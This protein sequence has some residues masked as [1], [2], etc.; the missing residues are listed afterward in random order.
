IGGPF[1]G[2]NY[3]NDHIGHD[4]DGDGFSDLNIPY[5]P[6]DHLP[7]VPVNHAPVANFTYAPT[8]PSSL[9]VV[10]FNDTSTD[11]DGN[12][13]I[14]NWSWIFGDGNSSY[15]QN[16]THTYT[17]NG[18]F[19]VIL[20][21][22][23]SS[24]VE[25]S[26][27]QNI[28]ILNIGPIANFSYSPSN[29]HT[30]IDVIFNS[31]SIDYDGSIVNWSWDFD[32]GNISYGE[33]TTHQFLEG[34][35]N[36]VLFIRDNTG[37]TNFTNK[38]ITVTNIQ[39]NVDFTYFPV[40]PTTADIISFIDQSSDRNERNIVNW[41]WDFDDGN[42]SYT[43]NPTHQ[44]ANSGDYNVTLT[45]TDN[46]MATNSTTKIVPVSNLP[47]IANFSYNPNNPTSLDL[48][49]FNDSSYDSDGT[50]VSWYWNFGDG[51]TSTSQN[52][53]HSYADN[54]TYLVS[55]TVTDDDGDNDTITKQV[56]LANIIPIVNF[57]YLPTTP[58]T[59][60]LIT[61]NDSSYD[62]DGTI[63]SWY[64]DFDD[65]NTSTS[66]N[67]THSYADNG[68]YLVSL[69]VTDDDGASN[70]T[71]KPI[72]ILN[73]GPTAN[74]SYV[75]LSPQSD[76]M[77]D[78][79]D[80]STDSDGVI[81]NW[82]WIFDDGNISNN[83]HPNHQY[84]DSGLY[85]VT[86]IVTD[87][88]GMNDSYWIII[89]VTNTA[90]VASFSWSPT[91]P[92]TQDNI[93]FIDLSSDYDGVVV[94]WYWDF[95]D[96]NYSS[97]QYPS[98]QYPE[99]GVYNVTLTI[100]DDDGAVDATTRS[101][102]VFNVAPVA[103]FSVSSDNVSTFDII[104]FTDSSSDID[105]I[106]VN[107]SWDFD[108][109]SGSYEQNPTHNYSND[110][111][112]IINLTVMDNDG[113]IGSIEKQI[114]VNN[115]DPFANFSYLPLNPST[116]DTVN[117]TD[118]SIDLDGTIVSWYWDFDDSYFNSNQ[119]PTHQYADD[120]VYNVTLTV[121]D[122]DGASNV[123]IYQIIVTNVGPSAAFTYTPPSPTDLDTILFTDTSTDPDGVIV[124][125]TWNFGDGNI[126]YNQHPN[127][128]FDD[129]GSYNVS[130]IVT[131]DD[132]ENVS[133]SEV[134]IVGNVPPTANF[135]FVPLYPSPL[136]TISFIDT[137]TDPDGVIVNWT[138]NFGDGNISFLQN[139]THAYNVSDIYNVTLTITD[140]DGDNDTLILSININL[141]PSVD[142]T[143][144]PLN[145]S[146]A[147]TIIFTDISTDFDGTIVNWSWDF[148]DGNISYLQNPTHRYGDNGSYNATLSIID[149]DNATNS[150]W[151][152]ISVNNSHPEPDFTW[153]PLFPSTQDVVYFTDLS[154]DRS[155]VSW[156]WNFG[157]NTS[158]TTQHPS[159]Q[160]A[161]DGV[162]NVTLTVTDDDGAI[163]STTKPI[164][165]SNV[166]P[167]VGFDYLPLDP[168][169]ND[170]I[171]FTDNSSDLDGVIVNWSWDFG[172]GNISYTKNATHQYEHEGNY[173]VCLTI[174]DDDSASNTT[175]KYVNVV[176]TTPEII[177]VN[178]SVFDRGFPIR[179][180][181]DGDWAGAQSFNP[182]IST[183]TRVDVYLRKFGVPEF[184]LTV[185]LRADDP[186]GSLI[187]TVVFTH[188]EVNTSFTWLSVNF[189][190]TTV[191]PGTEYFIVIP[192]A[193]SGVTSSFGYEWGYAFGNQY[194]NGSFW[195]T[196]DGG[197]LWRDLPSMYEFVF[198]T[199]GYL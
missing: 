177:D 56:S 136:E 59:A 98:H 171:T 115:R 97:A 33:N 47:P 19:T 129:D 52:T 148:G 68:T 170:T 138:W 9:D 111:V 23:D 179:H 105:G 140:D 65:G 92:T 167:I 43:Q 172:D 185:E 31:T 17:S 117:F 75:P 71:I 80:E 45:I 21:I 182:T 58:T 82:T 122:D 40:H 99:N 169:T 39:P 14:V 156:S 151:K 158:N 174:L 161:D 132:G 106:I 194:N 78:F 110:G 101:L 70:S 149:D 188:A 142:F 191:V 16:A 18:N 121:W 103:N 173:T 55:L 152:I 113:D 25:N 81:V 53:T 134:V 28:T 72:T 139:P 3:W 153:M 193:P 146:T 44:Y 51:N 63:V 93:N 74:F 147:D 196:R 24:G 48:I 7:L 49:S 168:T 8:N 112:Y 181:V 42:I 60:D 79:T 90:P 198:R 12:I 54:G 107:W 85:N 114:T 11:P 1:I 125:W 187:D 50:I 100:S 159:H 66:Q 118:L 104:S 175:C 162:Y 124:N 166:A 176:S 123:T 69:T 155:I 36:V 20:F 73:I 150:T 116:A 46:D 61:F 130:L 183:I 38:T 102:E 95:D 137:S 197:T 192:P 133:Y 108:D 15:D 67:T 131:D 199:Y 77:I 160:Y 6:G 87:D 2:G 184:N 120:G 10:Q 37:A 190:D 13:D 96:G 76:E 83:Q 88:D 186:E 41:S 86:L 35:Y 22:L 127:H 89:N 29:P 144:I 180:A 135:T 141:V 27:Q 57:S 32:D 109:G 64:W 154:T 34:V 164:T 178:Q 165:V 189:T 143:Y 84:A 5:G 91:N 128:Q 26:T 119:N 126:S 157:D 62:S 94:S 30:N 4:I 163:N 145:P 195:F